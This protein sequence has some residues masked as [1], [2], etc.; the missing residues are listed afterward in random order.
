MGRWRLKRRGGLRGLFC[1]FA[2]GPFPSP[3]F[4]I[5][6]TLHEHAG[7]LV[8]HSLFY[9]IFSFI[10]LFFASALLRGLASAYAPFFGRFYSS[11]HVVGMGPLTLIPSFWLDI[12]SFW[13]H[14]RHCPLTLTHS[15]LSFFWLAGFLI[16]SPS[17]TFLGACWLASFL[18][19]DRSISSSASTLLR[20]R[21]LL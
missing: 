9:L 21:R 14:R 4:S 7:L 15:F 11:G 2:A 16:L 3:R 17:S 13:T 6:S 5:F 19:Y 12:H 1:F 8:C 20:L 18:T 10:F